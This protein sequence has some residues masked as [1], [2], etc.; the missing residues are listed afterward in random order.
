MP[1]SLQA[2]MIRRA[3]SPRLAIRIRLYIV[4]WPED[5]QRRVLLAGID[6]EQRLV[7]FDGFAICLQPGDDRAPYFGRNLV[8]DIHG[9]HN[10]DGRVRIDGVADL[11]ERIRLGIGPRIERADHRA[12]DDRNAGT[13]HGDGFATT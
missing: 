13:V 9:F 6:L 4:G 10:A 8:E 7:E 11:D 2:R 12:L 1:S 5:R 3:I